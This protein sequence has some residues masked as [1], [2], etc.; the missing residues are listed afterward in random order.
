MQKVLVVLCLIFC[1]FLLFG[2]P[3]QASHKTNQPQSTSGVEKATVN[4]KTDSSGMTVEQQNIAKRLEAD[5]KPGAMKHLYIISAYSGEVIMYSAVKGKVTSGKKRLTPRTVAAIDGDMVGEPHNGIPIVIGNKWH[6]TS[7]VLEDDGTYG[8]S[9]DYIYWWDT[10]GI[11]HQHMVTGGQIIH[12]SDA[13][14]NVK[15]VMINITTG[16]NE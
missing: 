4:L 13:P 5:N 10:K 14:L 6:W 15:R 2:C 7:E 9:M 1:I 16:V 12:I 3:Q 11:Y 8:E